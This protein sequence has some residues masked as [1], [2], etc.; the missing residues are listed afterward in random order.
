MIGVGVEVMGEEGDV[1]VVS[2]LMSVL[3]VEW[4][5]LM[6]VLWK[7]VVEMGI[8]GV[9]LVVVVGVVLKLWRWFGMFLLMVLFR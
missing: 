9:E 6:W 7:F 1:V 4:K 3:M 2:D 8:I 5:L